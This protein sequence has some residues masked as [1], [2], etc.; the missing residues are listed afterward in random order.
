MSVFSNPQGRPPGVR[1]LL[2]LLAAFPEGLTLR[3]IQA[4]MSPTSERTNADEE[5]GEGSSR[6]RIANTMGVARSLKLIEAAG[7]RHRVS[8]DVN[9]A[10]D[11]AT[12]VHERFVTTDD[13][14]DRLL[15]ALYAFIV[16]RSQREAGVGW[17]ADIKSKELADAADAA[18]KATGDE[19]AR[20][21][22]NTTRFASWKEW[23]SFIGLGHENLPK[24]PVFFLPEA[25]VRVGKELAVVGSR[26]GNDQPHPAAKVVGALSE[27]CPYLDG[28]SAYRA[29]AK[30][31]GVQEHTQLS[32]ILS[33]ALR[34]LSADQR[35]TLEGGG[36]TSESLI[37]MSDGVNRTEPVSRIRITSQIGAS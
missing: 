36:D 6:V 28:G 25:T 8:A 9:A 13:D 26:L 23:T 34:G 15:V 1:A 17:L 20:I 18:F 14:S 11:L 2:G 27:R 31:L 33:R 3:E 22:V 12:V 19:Y 10:T 37:L 21:T 7:D 32:P 35:I 29:L 16:C 24:V 30:V 4:W 5:P